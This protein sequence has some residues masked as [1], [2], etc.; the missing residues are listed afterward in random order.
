M[1]RLVEEIKENTGSKKVIY[2]M[3][4]TSHFW[5]NV[6]TYLESC[7]QEYVLVQPLSVKHERKSTYY[8]SSKDDDRDSEMIVNLTVDK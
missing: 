1:V 4:P 3:E 2:S 7:K 6:A 8:N 5:M